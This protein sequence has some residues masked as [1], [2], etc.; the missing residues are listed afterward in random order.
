MLSVRRK[1]S[2]LTASL[3]LTAELTLQ[4]VQLTI[5]MLY[6]LC[7]LSCTV[8]WLLLIDC[9]RVR[10][11][12]VR[13]QSSQDQLMQIVLQ[14]MQQLQ[15]QRLVSWY[16]FCDICLKSLRCLETPDSVFVT[17]S[18]FLEM[19][20]GEVWAWGRGEAGQLGNKTAKSEVNYTYC[21]QCI[22]AE[23]L[24][25]LHLQRLYSNE[26]FLLGAASRSKERVT[27]CP[28]CSG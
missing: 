2:L 16:K 23:S 26:C 20:K 14:V 1:H 5:D 18:P 21:F 25:M 7:L 28:H 8:Y 19:T 13:E 27:V 11:G 6:E 17:V 4:P 15:F 3:L 12:S 9:M 22:K 10:P 24:E